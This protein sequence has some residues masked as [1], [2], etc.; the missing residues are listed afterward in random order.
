MLAVQVSRNGLLC[1]TTCPPHAA[2]AARRAAVHGC[3]PNGLSLVVKEL[4]YFLVRFPVITR[5]Y[6]NTW[7]RESLW[8]PSARCFP[9]ETWWSCC[10]HQGLVC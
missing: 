1:C 4:Q 6:K 5:Y 3:S 2:T 9:V 10:G 8:F 7:T